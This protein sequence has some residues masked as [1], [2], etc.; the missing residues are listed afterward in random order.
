MSGHSKWASIKHKKGANDAKRGR[1]FTKLIREITVAAKNGGGS[2][3][4]NAALRSAITRANEANMPKD[5]I[6]KAIKKGTGELPGVVYEELAFEGYGP[7]GV[8]IIVETLTD[9]KNRASAEIRN[10]FSK[11]GGNMAGS[12]SVS[13][14]FTPK[15]Y[16]LVD[17]SQTNEDDLFAISV[18]AGAEDVDASGN[19]FEVYCDPKDFENVKKAIAD[20]GIKWETAELTQV[21]NSTIKVTGSQAKQVLG[22]VETLEE[23]DDVQKV[24]AN[25]DIPEELLEELAQ[26]L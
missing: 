8:A 19:N 4:T 13:W 6:D 14:I 26:E 20:K 16:I 17:K 1:I 15:G 18:D 22:L 3:D 9:N 23:H 24:H 10:I 7:G 2:P 5:N 21:P 25:F 11:R 12:G